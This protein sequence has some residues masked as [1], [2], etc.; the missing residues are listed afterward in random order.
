[1]PK[2]RRVVTRAHQ[3]ARVKAARWM[4]TH[5]DRKIREQW[6]QFLAESYE[7]ENRNEVTR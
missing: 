5:R 3:R 6:A 1:M 7:E 4:R 2:E